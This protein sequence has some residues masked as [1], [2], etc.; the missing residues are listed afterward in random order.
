MAVITINSNTLTGIG[1]F[2]NV[3]TAF[4]NSKQT[5]STLLDSLNSLKI[6][7]DSIGNQV[8]IS[9]SS[10]CV[11]RCQVR[12]QNKK[13]ALSVAYDKLDGFISNIEKVDSTVAEKVN[14]LKDEFYGKYT[15]LKPNC[16]K[17][18]FE[19][20]VDGTQQ[21]WKNICSVNQAINQFIKNA[22]DWCKEHWE[23]LLMIITAIVAA[24]V[25]VVLCVLTFGAAA[26]LLSVLVCVLV[27]VLSQLIS[28]LVVFACTG[29]WQST[30]EDYVGAA[31]GGI[32]E[33]ALTLVNPVLG[34]SVGGYYSSMFTESLK[35]LTGKQN[36]S[37]LEIQVN[38]F[39]NAG[40]SAL[41]SFGGEKIGEKLS[42]KLSKIKIFER[43]SGKNSYKVMYERTIKNL[44]KKVYT[45]FTIK[46][47]GNGV[48]SQLVEFIPTSILNGFVNYTDIKFEW[49]KKISNFVNT[50]VKIVDI[51][52]RITFDLFKFYDLSFTGY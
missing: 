44:Q 37:V 24:V 50:S 17:N 43:F 48:I 4:S 49:Q 3:K 6:K 8:D 31:F 30:W 25:I 36:K 47:V 51:S 21:L 34:A 22:V 18:D 16:E 1:G 15:Y 38:S 9:T 46:S 2:G 33:G 20:F 27:S 41:F 45:K 19:K 42:P 40:I 7:T 12:E 29:E 11:K 13:S 52:F 32:V 14:E 5:T 26:V 23:S 10:D 35:N 28:D 39:I